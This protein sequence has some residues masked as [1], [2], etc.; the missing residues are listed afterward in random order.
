MAFND[1]IKR[2]KTDGDE[3]TWNALCTN[4]LL[5]A[6]KV[7]T[8][9]NFVRYPAHQKDDMIQEAV[10]DMMRGWRKYDPER[11]DANIFA[12]FTQIVFNASKLEI[13]HYKRR[14]KIFQ[15]DNGIGLESLSSEPGE[16]EETV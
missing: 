8:R 3:K 7:L 6:R 13:K 2:M 11:P 14:T 10:F 15:V 1:L 12:Y 4:F 5:I 16:T 9:G